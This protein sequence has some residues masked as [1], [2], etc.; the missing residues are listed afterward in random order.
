LAAALY[1]VAY[2]EFKPKPRG[3]GMERNGEEVVARG[4]V[5]VARVEGWER[6]SKKGGGLRC[7][8]V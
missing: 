3:K 5:S 8:G 1:E 2:N 4:G 7:I 6:R